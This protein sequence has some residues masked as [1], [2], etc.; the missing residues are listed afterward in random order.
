MV[1]PR[2]L[3]CELAEYSVLVDGQKAVLLV[4]H[5]PELQ[6][7]V[8]GEIRAIDGTVLYRTELIDLREGGKSSLE[9]VGLSAIAPQ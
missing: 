8:A 9:E 1:G 7:D 4:E 5:S 2:E 3:D 6:R